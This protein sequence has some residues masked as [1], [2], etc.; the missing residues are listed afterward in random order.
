MPPSSVSFRPLLSPL[1]SLPDAPG[2]HYRRRH[3]TSSPSLEHYHPHN[4]SPSTRRWGEDLVAPPCLATSPRCPSRGGED[5]VDREATD[6]PRRPRHRA[7]THD[8]VT[9]RGAAPAGMGRWARPKVGSRATVWPSAVRP[10]FKFLFS[11]I[12]L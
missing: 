7:C 11:F 2:R 9:T 4:P 1:G 6:E 10:S 8:T 5:L 12:I 3:R